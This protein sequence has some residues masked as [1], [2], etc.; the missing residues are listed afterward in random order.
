MKV[1]CH[2]GY[3]ISL[4]AGKIYE[5]IGIEYGMFRIVDNTEEDYLFSPKAS[6]HLKD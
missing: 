3:G 4:T 5:V 6:P 1:R 2:T